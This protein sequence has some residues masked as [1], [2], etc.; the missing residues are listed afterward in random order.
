MDTRDYF[1]Q[2][3]GKCACASCIHDLAEIYKKMCVCAYDHTIEVIVFF[4]I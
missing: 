4:I 1:L 2:L 3:Q